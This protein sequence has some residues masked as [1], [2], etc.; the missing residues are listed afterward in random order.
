MSTDATTVPGRLRTQLSSN[1]K[2]GCLRT[3]GPYQVYGP[4]CLT[5]NPGVYGHAVHIVYGPGGLKV[6]YR[7]RRL[8]CQT[9]LSFL[10]F[11]HRPVRSCRLTTAIVVA[12]DEMMTMMTTMATENDAAETAAAETTTADGVVARMTTSTRSWTTTSRR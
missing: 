4:S 9:S 7:R 10:F 3:R 2:A 12:D 5:I 8:D 1:Y 11:R 6:I